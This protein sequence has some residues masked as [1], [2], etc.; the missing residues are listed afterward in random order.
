M[1]RHSAITE[2]VERSV[3]AGLSLD[4]VRDFSRHKTI[5][6]LLEYRDRLMN[7]QPRLATLVA[8]SVQPAARTKQGTE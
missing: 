5:N 1:L 6:I 8:E 7:A 2:A 3:A 4:Q